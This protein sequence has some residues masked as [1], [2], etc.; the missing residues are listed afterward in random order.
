MP[1]VQKVSRIAFF[2]KVSERSVP[3]PGL[4]CFNLALVYA[5]GSVTHEYTRRVSRLASGRKLGE[6]TAHLD[7]QTKTAN[8]PNET[9]YESTSIT[10]SARET[11]LS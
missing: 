8:E 2:A 10:C 7:T 5:S 3:P 1:T 6:A 9:T 4:V 11:S